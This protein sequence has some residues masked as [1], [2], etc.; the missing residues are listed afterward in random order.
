MNAESSLNSK[1]I[2]QLTHYEGEKWLPM[3]L[4]DHVRPWLDEGKH[5]FRQRKRG[6]RR[7]RHAID[8]QV[9]QYPWVWP[10]RRIIFISDL[11]ADADALL[12]SLVASGGVIRTGKG[13]NKFKLSKQ[14]KKSVFVFGGDF[15]D[16]GPSNLR[17]L[18]VLKNLIDQ[19]ARVKLLAGN[20]DVRVLFGMRTAGCAADVKNGHFFV[21]MGAKAI[22]LLKEIRN[23]YLSGKN[24]LADVP[25]T[26]QCRQL[27]L[28]QNTWFAGFQEAAKSQLSPAACERE[29]AKIAKKSAEFED[30]CHKAGLTLREVYASALLWQKLFLS[31]SGEFYWFYKKLRLALKRGSFLFVHAGLDDNL[32]NEISTR[33]L[34]PLNKEFAKQLK[35]SPFDFYYGS[36]ANSIRTKYRAVDH[37]LS[38]HGAR[39][40][41]SAG[42][43]AIV[44]GHR[45][46]HRG[47]RLALRRELLHI[48]C[49]I[50]LD[51]HSRKKESLKGLGAG[52]T[53]IDP[54][55]FVAG[56]SSDWP[57][58]KLFQ[59]QAK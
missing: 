49:D 46:L 54:K 11:H 52:A 32:A 45:N 20:H 8:Q 40:T 28:P 12:A 35:G 55:G 26:K 25:D 38:K 5:A 36:L 58:I 39:R 2:S 34:T 7:A 22:P 18:R 37:P 21:R 30:Q 59:P 19:K 10:K 4:P 57:A 43:H 3:T 41:H 44:H 9:S 14:G 6:R 16:K 53:I 31:K 48:E 13:D 51:K 24:A 27:L 47:Q 29:L 33:G 23:E 50:T 56:I 42:I 1:A 15:F 17:L